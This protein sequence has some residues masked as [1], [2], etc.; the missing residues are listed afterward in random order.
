[1][2]IRAENVGSRTVGAILKEPLRVPAYQRPYSWRVPTALQLL[3]DVEEASRD[4]AR[5]ATPY[6]L[7]AVI[8]HANDKHL[9]IVDGQQRL[10]TLTMLVRLL[11][12]SAALPVD[13]DQNAPLSQ[14]WN[15]LGSRV[16][17]FGDEK[18]RVVLGTVLERCVLVRIVTDDV[19]EAFRVFDSQNYRGKPLAPHD[20]L[21]AYHLREMASEPKAI[22]RAVV[23]TWESVEDADLDLLFSTY[24]YRII[25]WS[26]GERAETFTTHDIDVFKGISLNRKLS[27]SARYHV[28][29]KA[30]VP[31]MGGVGP[32]M[33]PGEKEI[34]GHARFQIDTPVVA[35]RPFFEMIAFFLEELRGLRT[36]AFDHGWER[37]TSTDPATMRERVDRSRYRKVNELYLAAV[38]YFTNRFGPADDTAKRALF[39]WAYTL[40]LT[41]QRVQAKSVDKRASGDGG[42]GLFTRIRNASAPSVALRY[43]RAELAD[44]PGH[45]EDL[46]NLLKELTTA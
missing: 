19:D 6:V 1:M 22:Q 12:G 40:R 27:P 42:T 31:L 46:A 3:E 29:A 30:A 13:A 21:K 9:D 14:V 26:R 5:E 41:H 20:L 16:K 34:L 38:L 36:L 17:T 8:L 18:R 28:A 4:V 32:S 23:D 10:L 37:F 11:E 2:T 24:L 25:K 43:A 44:A 33:S 7:G 15:A 39:A 45:D 35:G